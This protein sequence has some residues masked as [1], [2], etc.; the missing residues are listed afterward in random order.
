MRIKTLLLKGGVG[1]L[2]GGV[3]IHMYSFM[4]NLYKTESAVIQGLSILY[5]A[6]QAI[7]NYT[8]YT[9]IYNDRCL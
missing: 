6:I 7:Q 1:V 3:G 2:G 9:R 4:S 8:N 5:K